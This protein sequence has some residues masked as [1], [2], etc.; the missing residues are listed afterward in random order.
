MLDIVE[1]KT[2]VRPPSL[3]ATGID[4]LPSSCCFTFFFGSMSNISE[5]RSQ[6]FCFQKGLKLPAL[7]TIKAALDPPAPR[8]RASSL[9]LELELEFGPARDRIVN[10]LAIATAVN[11]NAGLNKGAKVKVSLRMVL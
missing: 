9:E 10:C 8:A 6:S 4:S 7:L 1:D 5:N 2:S 11:G 3:P